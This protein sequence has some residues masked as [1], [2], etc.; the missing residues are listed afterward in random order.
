MLSY[1]SKKEKFIFLA[2]SKAGSTSLSELL[3]SS[4][5]APGKVIIEAPSIL[6]HPTLSE[7]CYS[8]DITPEEL[9]EYRII[10]IVRNPYDRFISS[11]YS[12]SKLFDPLS[13]LETVIDNLEKCKYLLPQN[14]DLFYASFYGSLD[15][16]TYSLTQTNS[17]GG[18]RFWYE[19][20]Y[21][22]NLNADINIFKL[23]DLNKDSKPLTDLLGMK[24]VDFPVKRKGK[25]N[26]PKL[27]KELK[28]KIYNLYQKDFKLY[29]YRK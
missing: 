1:C 22:N 3:Q 5:I 15:Y 12:Q 25:Y 18:M 20:N 13:N 11:Y 21:W 14:E 9:K 23:E 7:I 10:Q 26:K 16:K 24:P 6:Y 19:Q 8:Y 2:T 29:K 27:S 28:N 4:N 17:W